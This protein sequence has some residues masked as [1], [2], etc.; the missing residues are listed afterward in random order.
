VGVLVQLGGASNCMTDGE[1]LAGSTLTWWDC[2][3]WWKN[4]SLQDMFRY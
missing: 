2:C 1:C 4:R 3:C